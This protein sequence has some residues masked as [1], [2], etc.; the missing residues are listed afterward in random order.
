[1]SEKLENKSNARRKLLKGIAAGSGAVIAGKTLPES[2]SRPVIDSVMLPAHAQTSLRSFTNRLTGAAI[3]P[4][5]QFARVLGGL[6]NEAHA[7]PGMPPPIMAME[8]TCL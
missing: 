5:S 8:R 2:W 4:D 1:M 3:E 6:V 7:G